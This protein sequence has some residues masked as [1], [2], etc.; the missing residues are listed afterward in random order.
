MNTNNYLFFN[1][2]LT[3]DIPFFEIM[4]CQFLHFGPAAKI[5]CLPTTTLQIKNSH[6]KACSSMWFGI[7]MGHNANVILKDNIIEDAQYAVKATDNCQTILVNNDMNDNFV[8]YY[9]EPNVSPQMISGSI[10]E[11]RFSTVN[12]LVQPYLGQTPA[13]STHSFAGIWINDVTALTIGS[14]NP[15]LPKNI[16]TNLNNGIISNRTNLT[17]RYNIFNDIS[18]KGGYNNLT[19][20][21]LYNHSGTGITAYGGIGYTADI[22]GDAGPGNAVEFMNC[23]YGIYVD[24]LEAKVYDHQFTTNNITGINH[25][26][27]TVVN[28]NHVLTE[29]YKNTIDATR[30]GIRA[31]ENY[32]SVILTENTITINNPANNTFLRSGIA[33]SNFTTNIGAVIDVHHNHIYM[34]DARRGIRLRNVA[35]AWVHENEVWML[36]PNIYHAG[37]VYDYGI[38]VANSP[39]CTIDCNNVTGNFYQGDPGAKPQ[40][41]AFAWN[42]STDNIVS[43]NISDNT[44]VGFNFTG[45]CNNTDFKGNQIERHWAGLRLASSVFGIQLNK[46]NTWLD[47]F[48]YPKFGAWLDG[49]IGAPNSFY[50]PTGLPFTPSVSA[51]LWFF[52]GS[53]PN[54]C[55]NFYCNAPYRLGGDSSIINE[56]EWLAING[57]TIVSDFN[58]QVSDDTKKRLFEK[59]ENYMAL[60]T[61]SNAAQFFTIAQTSALSQTQ[62]VKNKLREIENDVSYNQPSFTILSNALTIM[63]HQFQLNDS[64][65]QITND[66]LLQLSLVAQN[67]NIGKAIDSL[68]TQIKILES[69]EDNIINQKL[70]EAKTL[71]S[72]INSQ[73]IFDYNWSI[74][75]EIY[76]TTI[77][78]GNH[79]LSSNQIMDATDIATQCPLIG[80]PAVY[81]ARPIV[82][83]FDENIEYNEQAVCL[84]QGTVM[85]KV[86]TEYALLKT[87]IRM[88]PNP[89]KDMLSFELNGNAFLYLKIFNAYGKLLEVRNVNT[90]AT[91]TLE[92]NNLSNGV[93]QFVLEGISIKKQGNFIILK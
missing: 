74:I 89:A 71:N 81:L 1:G 72:N 34:N 82:E 21:T 37:G 67:K 19:N 47:P 26:G 10:Q 75:M 15:T 77:A 45:A 90:N 48:T 22:A 33:I 55:T 14:F 68:N 20:T 61:N 42:L 8:S 4:N 78:K 87:E 25:I 5:I 53:S 7:E 41:F 79:N 63:L 43:C 32:A 28:M 59:M 49:S 31:T 12:Q 46:S 54:V 56:D 51:L 73:K 88:Y 83:L 52:N 76:L 35:G 44:D 64:I 23:F 39:N 18:I 40:T 91:I 2:T 30:F 62:D 29:V 84:G 24:A 3:V 13:I 36:Y 60:Q 57:D 27:V 80:G 92:T 17:S 9:V 69:A 50:T 85:R 86:E 11:N 58:P 70:D 93:Y 66:S 6:L 65:I 16:F 38:L